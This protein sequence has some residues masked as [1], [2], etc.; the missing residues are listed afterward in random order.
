[1]GN[2]AVLWRRGRT[3]C[4][5]R[6]ERGEMRSEL[7]RAFPSCNGDGVNRREAEDAEKNQKI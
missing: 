4:G 5:E 3:K 1:M 6:D 2:V 7:E